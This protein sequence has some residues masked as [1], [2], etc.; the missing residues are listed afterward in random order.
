MLVAMSDVKTVSLTGVAAQSLGWEEPKKKRATRSKR[1]GG[2]EEERPVIRVEEP[3]RSFDTP[4]PIQNASM[5]PIKPMAEMV[6]M[7]SL[8]PV[9]VEAPKPVAE[10]SEAE[11]TAGARSI[12]VEL[13]RRQTAKKVQLHPKRAVTAG[14]STVTKKARK[15]FLGVSSQHKRMT[16]A[17]KMHHAIKIMPIATLREQLVKKG[18]IKATSKAPETVL[19]QMAADAQIVAAKAL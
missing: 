3:L 17:K 12:R 8:Q 7:V 4:R 9:P 6:K 13:K 5:Q 15:V 10:T 19:R 18:L 14:K 11:Q 16:R 2:A 1:K